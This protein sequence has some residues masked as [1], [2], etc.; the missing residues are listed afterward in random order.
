MLEILLEQ[1]RKAEHNFQDFTL[2]VLKEIGNII[3]KA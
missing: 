3:K 2:T 1:E